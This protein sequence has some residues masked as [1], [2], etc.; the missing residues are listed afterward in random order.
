M[1]DKSNPYAEFGDFGEKPNPYQSP[2]AEHVATNSPLAGKPLTLGQI[3]FSTNGRIPRR[4]YWG[5]NISIILCTWMIVFAIAVLTSLLFDGDAAE[6]AT[7]LLILVMYPFVLW[8]IVCVQAKR[9]HDRN[10]S[11]WMFLVNFIPLIGPIWMFAE[12]GCTR[13]TFG[14]NQYGHD[15]T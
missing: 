5:A 13:G 1:N 3:L 8:A 9:W 6:T 11:A 4:V 2:A 12:C 10:Q 15:P 14:P 7:G